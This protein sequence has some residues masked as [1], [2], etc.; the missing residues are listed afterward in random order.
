MERKAHLLRIVE[1]YRKMRGVDYSRF[2]F[3]FIYQNALLR[4]DEMVPG[5]PG[6]AG[7]EGLEGLAIGELGEVIS[8]G[9]LGCVR[10]A[11]RSRIAPGVL[12]LVWKRVN[13]TSAVICMRPA[14][15]L[16]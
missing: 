5:L 11:V 3:F 7:L 16:F 13:N 9:T 12:Q 6:L 14:P 10:L 1:P 15:A 2:K 4:R 8:P